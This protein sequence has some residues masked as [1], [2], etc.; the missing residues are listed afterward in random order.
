MTLCSIVVQAST[1]ELPRTDSAVT[2]DGVMD[3]AAWR[4]ATQVE[5]GLETMPG[6]N[7]PAPVKTVAYLM[8]DGANLYIGFEASDPDPSS[9]RA[10]LRD[11]DSAF[12][13]DFVGIIID[14]YNDGQRAFE[15]LS[16]PNKSLNARRVV[17]AAYEF[18]AISR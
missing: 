10:Y 6:E 5:L 16:N 2:I 4:D 15:F 1:V 9:I 3:E 18:M 17:Y 13:D 7:I 8:E 14:T 11:R 12:N